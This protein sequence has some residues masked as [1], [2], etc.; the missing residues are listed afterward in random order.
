MR[1][2]KTLHESTMFANVL[3]AAALFVALGGVAYAAVHLPRNSVGTKHLKKKAVTKQK[4]AKSSVTSKA[5][6][7]RS[8][9][10]RDFA[11]GQLPRGKRGPAG[12]Q[13]PAGERGP[14]GE[15]GPEGPAGSAWI[16]VVNADGGT[17][18]SVGT[19]P[20]GDP[21]VIAAHRSGEG[22]Y[23]VNF[24]WEVDRCPRIATLGEPF[25][26]DSDLIAGPGTP[27]MIETYNWPLGKTEIGVRTY[28]KDGAPADRGFQIAAYC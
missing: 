11:R 13:G 1:I 22:M 17:V 16:A 5:V 8:L 19:G 27:G 14:E 15:Q 2:L 12:E 9:K 23:E 25:T 21:I 18:K 26:E 7:D 24:G 3:A 4:L 10:K 20:G 28:D 6:K